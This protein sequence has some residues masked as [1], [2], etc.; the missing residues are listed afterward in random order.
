MVWAEAPVSAAAAAS[1][2]ENFILKALDCR[3]E[4]GAIGLMDGKKAEQS[5]GSR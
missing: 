5:E 4:E 2:D 3:L 1:E